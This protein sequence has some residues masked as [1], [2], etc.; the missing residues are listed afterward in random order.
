MFPDSGWKEE[1]WYSYLIYGN[2]PLLV[3]LVNSDP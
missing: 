3:D 2:I 1:I